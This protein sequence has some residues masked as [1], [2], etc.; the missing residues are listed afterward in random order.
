MLGTK[1][2]L[3]DAILREPRER[4][5]K[6]PIKKKLEDVMSVHLIVKIH[7]VNSTDRKIA[8]VTYTE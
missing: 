2:V 7:E 4:K 3:L 1:K 8:Q 6:P 5:E